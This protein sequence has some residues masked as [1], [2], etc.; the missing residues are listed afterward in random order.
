MLSAS[1]DFQCIWEP[2]FL[3]RTYP[4]IVRKTFTEKSGLGWDL[5]N[6]LQLCWQRWDEVTWAGRWGKGGGWGRTTGDVEQDKG[7]SQLLGAEPG[8]GME[9]DTV[10]P[11]AGASAAS[12]PARRTWLNAHGLAGAPAVLFQALLNWCY[13]D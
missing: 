1:R 6:E 8:M 7:V 11:A 2:V 4:A 9:G 5:K 12:S 3:S 13:Q 10:S